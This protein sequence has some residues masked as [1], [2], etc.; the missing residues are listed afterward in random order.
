MSKS[1][2]SS[3]QKQLFKTQM[4]PAKP[5]SGKLF[6][7]EYVVEQGPVECLGM[8]F[9]NDE[10]RREYFLEK[11]SEKLK[12]PEFRKI[13]GFPI[14]EDED[15]LALSDPPYYTA[16]P[17]PF[18]TEIANVG[19]DI[20]G[21]NQIH[22]KAF[23]DD[24]SGT[25]HS[26]IYN[27]HTY[28][29][30]VPPEA[31]SPLIAHYTKPGDLIL[32]PFAGTGMTAVA[33]AQCDENQE[34]QISRRVVL[35][36][37]SPIAMYIAAHHSARSGNRLSLA[38]SLRKAIGEV[39]GDCASL[40]E[41]AHTG[42]V[43]SEARSLTE[44]PQ[45]REAKP[46]EVGE[47]VYTVWSDVYSCPECAQEFVYWNEAV[48]LFKCKVLDVIF[49]PNCN[50]KLCKEP[51]FTKKGSA[52]LIE[53]AMETW[54]DPL[55]GAPVPR[56][57]KAPVLISYEYQRKRYEKYPSKEDIHNISSSDSLTPDMTPTPML[58]KGESWG[59]TWRAGVHLGITH[60]HHFYTNRNLYALAAIRRACP[61]RRL[62]FALTSCALR[63]S[64]MNRY[65]PQHR[66]N[67]SREVVGPLSGTLYVPAIGIEVNPFKYIKEKL[68]DIEKLW[69]RS[70][71]AGAFC[72]TQ[73]S[74]DCQQLSDNSVDYVFLDPPFGDNLFYSELNFIWEWWLGVFTRRE[75]EAVVSP[76]MNKSIHEYTV[77]MTNALRECVR[78]LKPGRW[79][80]MEF[81]NSQNAVW[82]AINEAL[83]SAGL[84]VADV[85]ILDKKKGT[86][87]QLTFANSVKKDLVI[88]AYK[89]N[90]G[91][92]ER[93]NR[94]AG[95]NDGVWDFIRTHLKQLPV[96]VSKDGQAEIIAERQNYLLFDRVV[97]FHVQHGATVPMSAAEFYAGLE[98][99]F[100]PRDG[101]YFLSDQVAEYDKKRMTVK[102]VLQL[103]LFVSDEASAIQW[104][105]Q[106]F[107]KK[108]QTF[109]EIHPQFLKEIGGWQKHE[110]ALE[111]SELL[112][113]N[114]ILYDGKGEVP[115][116]IH[117]YLSTMF[118][119]LRNLSKDD[120]TLKA[121]SKDRWYVPDPSK[122]GD[123][124]K[125]RERRLMKEFDE[126]RE[127]RQ[128]RLKVFRLEAVRA[129]F[130][131]AW[132]DRD[133]NTIIA[134]AQKIP[135]NVL[136]EDPKLLMWYDQALTRS[137]EE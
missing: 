99:R 102:E 83:Q 71:Y 137:G 116:Q 106:R 124:E 128:K 130:K 20:D 19:D 80:T 135:E 79:L 44:Q 61:D 119:E 72:S 49:C 51:K 75:R 131:K 10:K 110:K 5:G 107:T 65:M 95:T 29:T 45:N 33:A 70:G 105:K 92:E 27:V 56:Q 38:Y 23:S 125:L 81:H 132:Q 52:Q 115:S 133:Y 59:D 96:F 64:R 58:F 85:R 41:T 60:A 122:A 134:V 7:E 97:A 28:H 32:D 30:K 100:P 101:M 22:T 63:L 108:P 15:I 69:S 35:V 42:W 31:I 54:F 89:P 118:K 26:R 66:G 87:K 68:K 73:S 48:D 18:L 46:G 74:A 98:Q 129:G 76:A 37:L 3:D 1:K 14:G 13:E 2:D 21:Q 77:L 47:I 121:K 94:E 120:L 9:E 88:S 34:A 36:E 109:Q 90:D 126:Y 123:L 53:R 78:V 11:L 103:Q 50:A 8:T 62:W 16:C 93:F 17:N 104:L 136:Q 4:V 12:D 57:K 113:E 25:K 82:A 67:R 91:L 40:F 114:F 43:A 6:D 86:T 111:L 117:S 55:L 127:S 39:S 24:L 84:I 112:K